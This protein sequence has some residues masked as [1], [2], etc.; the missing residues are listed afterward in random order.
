M[1]SKN[2]KQAIEIGW[3]A[4][5]IGKKGM[6]KKNFH[7]SGQFFEVALHFGMPKNFICIIDFAS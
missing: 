2:V 5:E 7:S 4:I 6:G 1:K 3:N